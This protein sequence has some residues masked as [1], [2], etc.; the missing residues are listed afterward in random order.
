M[1]VFLEETSAVTVPSAVKLLL[2]K[3]P[4][5]EPDVYVCSNCNSIE[6]EREIHLS[7]NCNEQSKNCTYIRNI[8]VCCGLQ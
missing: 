8:P 6:P 2:S 7:G 5:Q 1:H 3:R 4:L